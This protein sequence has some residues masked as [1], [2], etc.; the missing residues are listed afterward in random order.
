MTGK[1]T[2]YR[3]NYGERDKI[4]TYDH[5]DIAI[6][7]LIVDEKERPNFNK[8]IEMLDKKDIQP[9]CFSKQEAEINEAIS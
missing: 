2:T 4:A 9:P 1:Y 7:G 6:C 5:W 3:D 8:W